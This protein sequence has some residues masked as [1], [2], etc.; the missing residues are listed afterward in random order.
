GVPESEEM[1]RELREDIPKHFDMTDP[2]TVVEQTVE[3]F[4]DAESI[5]RVELVE[6]IRAALEGA[7][8]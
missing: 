2:M 6:R 7:I 4:L 3:S 1:S 8:Q 5:I